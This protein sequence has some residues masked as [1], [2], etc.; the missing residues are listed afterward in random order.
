MYT[1]GEG[2]K[3]GQKLHILIVHNVTLHC[4]V[5]HSASFSAGGKT[6]YRVA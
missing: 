5:V 4:S 1:F 6:E 3:S 2:K